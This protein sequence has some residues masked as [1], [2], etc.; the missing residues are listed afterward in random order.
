MNYDHLRVLDQLS[1]SE[2]R[3]PQEIAL[4]LSPGAA[5]SFWYGT[6][7]HVHAALRSLEE[8][9]Y[10]ERRQRDI[11]PERL[12]NRGGRPESEYRLTE[13]GVRR[14]VEND[15]RASLPNAVPSEA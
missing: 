2:W 1:H 3:S 12:A 11:S 14:R 15:Q 10:A 8:G 7:A 9:E 4:R 5:T 6:L 13:P